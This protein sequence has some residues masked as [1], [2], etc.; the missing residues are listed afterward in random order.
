[1]TSIERFVPAFGAKLR[2]APR[3]A[4]DGLP[5]YLDLIAGLVAKLKRRIALNYQNVVLIV[6]STGSGKSHLG[7]QIAEAMDPFFSLAGDYVY[8]PEDFADK[9]ERSDYEPVCPVTLMDEGTLV[10]NKLD[11]QTKNGKD[12]LKL[13]DISRT[14]GWTLIV[15]G[16]SMDE[17]N[18]KFLAVHV[19]YMIDAGA[20]PAVDGYKRR[21]WFK[22][23]RKHKSLFSKV[24]WEP[25]AWGVFKPLT[26]AK[27]KEYDAYK[28]RAIKRFKAFYAKRNKRQ[29]S[30]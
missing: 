19:D 29:E 26:P 24:Y 3:D 15:I 7:V 21:G 11:Y 25:V 9:I 13:L 2:R 30:E 22:I 28:E 6:G 1:M 10:F 20:G 4:D 16:P 18:S 8:G 27:K 12:I 5:I 23:Y 17:F 14:L